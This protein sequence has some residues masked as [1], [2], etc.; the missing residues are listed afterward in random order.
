[1]MGAGSCK[2]ESRVQKSSRNID[3][4][5]DSYSVS[6][7]SQRLQVSRVNLCATRH[8]IRGKRKL[9]VLDL[10]VEQTC[11]FLLVTVVSHLLSLGLNRDQFHAVCRRSNFII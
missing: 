3:I 10:Q 7:S 2:V 11:Q 6:E 1:M 9:Y 4:I 5:Y 8:L